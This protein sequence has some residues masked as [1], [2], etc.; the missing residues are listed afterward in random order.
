MIV[1]LDVKESVKK[2]T[3]FKILFFFLFWITSD[4][5]RSGRNEVYSLFCL[6]YEWEGFAHRL[7]VWFCA[8]VWN[9]FI[10][11]YFPAYTEHFTCHRQMIFLHS[12]SI[13]AQLI[14]RVV[15]RLDEITNVLFSNAALK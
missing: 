9:R 7:V 12:L 3:V 2:G 5:D 8:L 1:Y 4:Y 15:E 10:E 6:V 13:N 11:I 14:Q